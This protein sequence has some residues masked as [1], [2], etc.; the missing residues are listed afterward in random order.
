MKKLA[1]LF[2]VALLL[3]FSVNVL[4]CDKQHKE[5]K[6]ETTTTEASAPAPAK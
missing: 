2:S 3:T 4:A 6:E 1:T 5:D